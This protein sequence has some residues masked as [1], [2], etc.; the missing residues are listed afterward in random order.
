MN[1]QDLC[2]IVAVVSMC[3]TTS[4]GGC[5][6]DRTERPREAIKPSSRNTGRLEGMVRWGGDA[7]PSPTRVTNTT[8]PE[9]C[10]RAQT[11]ED[12]V[13]SHE[14]RGIAH[15]IVALKD[16]PQ[17]RAPTD[18][19][20]VIDNTGCR[21]EPHAAVL[22]VGGVIEAVNS[23][24]ILHT[25]HLYGAVEANLS[26]ATRGVRVSR[27]VDEPG[28]I[29]VKC[30]LHGW[31]QAFVRVD[32]HPYHAVTDER[33]RFVIEHVPEGSYPLEVWHEKLGSRETR[34]VVHPRATSTVEIEYPPPGGSEREGSDP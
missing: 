5:K 19:R 31:M 22:T 23:D 2:G 9:V 7:I 21:F 13:V 32:P 3:L 20:L 18:N 4:L 27:R 24:P 6:R 25:T 33:G 28:M 30:D 17:E 15:V 29:V 12:M 34:V 26:L 10:G 1:T 14:T 8:D 11:L 16:A